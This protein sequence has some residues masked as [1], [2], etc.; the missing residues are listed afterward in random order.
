M[1]FESFNKLLSSPQL[2][3]GLVG[4]LG[5]LS[6]HPRCQAGCAQELEPVPPAECF[7]HGGGVLPQQKLLLISYQNAQAG[8]LPP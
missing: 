1:K 4:H 7:K 8:F 5:H 3:E 6:P 2:L